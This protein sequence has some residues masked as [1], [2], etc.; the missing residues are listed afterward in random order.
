[1]IIPAKEIDL[2]LAKYRDY[3]QRPHL[4]YHREK[5]KGYAQNVQCH[6]YSGGNR[7]SAV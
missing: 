5:W 2:Q 7:H 3:Q 1:M 6:F 4:L